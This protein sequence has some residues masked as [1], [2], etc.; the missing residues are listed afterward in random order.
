MIKRTIA[1]EDDGISTSDI[2]K[3]NEVILDVDTPRILGWKRVN[4]QGIGG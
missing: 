3:R 1:N 2:L 4:L